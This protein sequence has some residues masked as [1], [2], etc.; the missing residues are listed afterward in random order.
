VNENGL[1]FTSKRYFR[2]LH[3]E[4]VHILLLPFVLGLVACFPPELIW[5]YGSYRQLVGLLGRQIGCVA[6]RH[7]TNTE[8]TQTS[9]PRVVFEP[10]IQV[11]ERAKK[12]HALDRAANVIGAFTFAGFKFME[13]LK[14]DDHFRL[15]Q[16]HEK[17]VLNPVRQQGFYINN[18]F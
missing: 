3:T 9:M 7:N 2:N 17:F 15:H 5:N 16:K 6:E 13:G 1:F 18:S 14:N 8:D 11:L 10:T 4:P 12:F